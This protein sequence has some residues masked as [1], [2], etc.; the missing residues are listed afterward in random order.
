M[1]F[2]DKLERL[3]EVFNNMLKREIQVLSAFNKRPVKEEVALAEPNFIQ[4]GASITDSVN[5]SA[6]QSFV[7]DSNS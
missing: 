4:Q 7:N 1:F 2:Q 6:V 3:E 5:Q